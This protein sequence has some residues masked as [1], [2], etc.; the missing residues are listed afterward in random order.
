M[1]SLATLVVVFI[2]SD[3]RELCSSGVMVGNVSPGDRRP[4][5]ARLV[6]ML[7][8]ALSRLSRSSRSSRS[9]LAKLAFDHLDHPQGK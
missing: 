3:G 5:M 2:R 4:L 6:R 8:R 9:S 7:L 1:L